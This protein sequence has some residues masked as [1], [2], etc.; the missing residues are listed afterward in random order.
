MHECFNIVAGPA[1]TPGGV[2]IRALEPLAGLETM[3][4]RRPRA[5][6]DRDL[7]NGPGKLTQALAIT[8]AHYGADLTRGPL[9]IRQGPPRAIEIHVSPRI[10]ITKCPDRPLR[11]TIAGN[12]FVSR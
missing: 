12:R 4:S 9:T 10:G 11:F 6:E 3:R 1:G 8:R 2:L 5:T 7:A